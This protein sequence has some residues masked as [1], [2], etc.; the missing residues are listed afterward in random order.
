MVKRQKNNREIGEQLKG[1]IKGLRQENR[2][3]KEIIK[4]YSLSRKMLIHELKNPL[5]SIAGFTS[6]LRGATPE[7]QEQY[8]SIFETS[9]EYMSGLIESIQLGELSKQQ[10]YENSKIITLEKIARECAQRQ[11]LFLEGEKIK[12]NFSYNKSTRFDPIT[13]YTNKGV[14]DVMWNTLFG[15]AL[16]HAPKGSLIAQGI[17]INEKDNLE[18]LMENETNGAAM[19]KVSGMGEGIG[20]MYSNKLINILGGALSNYNKPKIM[21]ERYQYTE[22]FGCKDQIG[23]TNKVWGVKIEIPMKELTKPL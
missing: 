10:I 17:R 16:N 12:L 5:H 20:T 23:C 9:S 4:D 2:K 19:R 22:T 18:I 1:I 21:M 15:N 13:I 6:L 7:E 3:Q 14:I 8:L 11:S